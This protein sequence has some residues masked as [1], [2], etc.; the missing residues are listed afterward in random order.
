M[1]ESI[2]I[3]CT[4]STHTLLQYSETLYSGVSIPLSHWCIL[5]NVYS[6]LPIS[7]KFI[8]VVP[9]FVQ[10]RFFAEFFCFPLYFDHD[11]FMHHALHVLDAPIYTGYSTLLRFKLRILDS[12]INAGAGIKYKK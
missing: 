12:V 2:L 9:I 4:L 5:Y 1:L 7:R 8:N 6:P 11:T 10:F 3:T